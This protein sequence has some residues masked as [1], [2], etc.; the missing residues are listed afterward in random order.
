MTSTPLLCY[1]MLIVQGYIDNPMKLGIMGLV[2][3]ALHCASLEA[4]DK[5]EHD[6]PSGLEERDGQEV[7]PAPQEITTAVTTDSSGLTDLIQQLMSY[8]YL[9]QAQQLLNYC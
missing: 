8:Q 9:M 4:Q 3:L 1:S 5:H 6:A 2:A 7:Q